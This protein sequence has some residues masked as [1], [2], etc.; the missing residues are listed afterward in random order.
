MPLEYLLTA[1]NDFWESSHLAKLWPASLYR[2]EWDCESLFQK[3]RKENEGRRGGT[4]TGKDMRRSEECT[5]LWC[6]RETSKVRVA[7]L[8]TLR[9]ADNSQLS[10]RC[11][12]YVAVFS[13]HH[14]NQF[15][16]QPKSTESSLLPTQH[17]RGWLS[18]C[19]C[20]CILSTSAQPGCNY[21]S[22]PGLGRP[23]AGKFS[24]AQEKGRVTR[25]TEDCLSVTQ[26]KHLWSHPHKTKATRGCLL[27]TNTRINPARAI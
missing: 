19:F 25:R 11:L 6:G 12:F 20:S 2:P 16:L 18:L 26:L 5:E 23:K 17:H 15:F 21:P 13:L 9:S 10:M 3:A 4:D 8:S 7:L 27:P 1:G 22:W 24:L 14:H